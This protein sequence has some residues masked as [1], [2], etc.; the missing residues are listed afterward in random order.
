MGDRISRIYKRLGLILAILF[1]CSLSPAGNP[2]LLKERSI[3]P[4]ERDQSEEQRYRDRL[5]RGIQGLLD[6]IRFTE[7]EIA[8]LKGEVDALKREV[9]ALSLGTIDSFYVIFSDTT[10]V[11]N[12]EKN[13]NAF[14]TP[15]D[16][17]YID[18]TDAIE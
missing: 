2:K 9:D 15:G 17:I 12:G 3:A 13:V 5:Q 8:T 11:Q 7:E 4:E 6:N 1:L 10:S 16:T 18:T 14:L